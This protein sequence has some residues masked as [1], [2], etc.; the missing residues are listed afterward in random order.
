MIG[1]LVLFAAIIVVGA[2]IGGAFFWQ[3]THYD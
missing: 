3:S 1:W 2:F